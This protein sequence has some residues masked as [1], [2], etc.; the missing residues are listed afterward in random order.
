[1]SMIRECYIGLGSN[2]GKRLFNL[3]KAIEFLQSNEQINV[4]DKSSIY[5]TD[6]MYFDT[7]NKFYNCVIKINTTYQPMQLLR[8]CKYYEKQCGRT[9]KMSHNKERQIDID[10]LTFGNL[11][12][13]KPNLK[14]P[15][16]KI[17]ER[18]FV[19]RPLIDINPNYKFVNNDNNIK[20][21][22]NSIDD[23]YKVLKLDHIKL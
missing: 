1:M 4:L 16:N 2:I 6:P 15:H 14:I 20:D 11:I 7:Q 21:I 22:L 5:L 19:L 8:K 17:F 18:K 10:I 13:N 23:T 3:K 9:M 12:I